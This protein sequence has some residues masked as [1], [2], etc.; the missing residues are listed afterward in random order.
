MKDIL[1]ASAMK[2]IRE[3]Y[4]AAVTA[5]EL[6]FQYNA[7]DEDAL[8]GALGQALLTP[9]TIVSDDVG[10]SFVFAI[11]HFKIRGRGRGAPEKKLGA[12]GVFQI[13]VSDTNGKLL[14]RKGLLFQSKKRWE[15]KGKDTLLSDQASRLAGTPGRGIVVDF[16]DKGYSTCPCEA[17]AKAEG[18]HHR[19]DKSDF[20]RLAATLGNDF[21]ECNIGVEGLFYDGTNEILHDPSQD[22]AIPQELSD[23][24]VFDTRVWRLT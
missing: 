15:S 20:S 24:H 4:Y 1:P 7:G 17:A 2:T 22:T 16:D 9:P 13:E 10:N 8:T 23:R 19:M 11:Y 6:G 18:N 14:R 12:D 5:A 21:L 3:R